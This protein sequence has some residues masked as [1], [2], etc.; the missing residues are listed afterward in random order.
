MSIVYI[1][2]F[3]Q[4]LVGLR[5]SPISNTLRDFFSGDSL[6]KVFACSL[7]SHTHTHARCPVRGSEY[8]AAVESLIGMGYER[9]EVVRALRASFNNPD[10]A[11]EYLLTVRSTPQSTSVMYAS[12]CIYMGDF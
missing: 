8:E 10:R 1:P 2:S 6:E 12:S 7:S 11:A 9:A 3:R 4:L 5:H